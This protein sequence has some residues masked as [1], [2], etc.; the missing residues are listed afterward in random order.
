MLKFSRDLLAMLDKSENKSL[1]VKP[2]SNPLMDY[3]QIS[4][5][6]YSRYCTGIARWILA[7][8]RRAD[9]PLGCVR[10]TSVPALFSERSVLLF[11][12]FETHLVVPKPSHCP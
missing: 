8:E 10:S 6:D 5:F 9:T 7:G 2:S 1:R 11:M 3:A 4:A 12:S